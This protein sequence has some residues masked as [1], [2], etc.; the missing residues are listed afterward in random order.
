MTSSLFRKGGAFTTRARKPRA[1]REER[2]DPIA[3][4]E[5]ELFIDNDNDADLYRQ[6]GLPILVN[7]AKK[8]EKGKY[9]P[10]KAAKLYKYLADNGAKK[11][12][13]VHGGNERTFSP[14]TRREVARRFAKNFG[15]EASL[16]NYDKDFIK[17]NSRR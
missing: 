10:I 4:R 14:D 7:L 3:A 5:L 16:G 8:R 2:P 17:R 6:Q 12:V 13:R 9:D 11:Y 1:P 15:L